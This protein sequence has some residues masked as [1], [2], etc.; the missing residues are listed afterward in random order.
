MAVAQNPYFTNMTTNTV[1]QLAPGVTFR[2][3]LCTSPLMDV[4]VLIVDMTDKNLELIPVYKLAGNVPN[5]SHERT[6]A[7][8]LR[9]DAIASVNAGYYNVTSGDPNIGMTNSYTEING[10]HIGGASGNL[11]AENN[12]SVV[13]FSGLHQ[14]IAK[15][16]KLNSSANPST[17]AQAVD[18]DKIT[19]A[20]A[21]RGHFITANGVVITQDNEGTTAGHYDSSRSRTAIGFSQNPY[22]AFLVTVDENSAQSSGVTYTQLA[23]IMADFGIENSI[24]LDGGGST[25]MYVFGRGMLTRTND[26][27][28]RSVVSAWNI[29]QANTMDNQA[30]EAVAAGTWTTDAAT[31]GAYYL[32]Q[33]VASPGA[34]GASTVTWTPT[35]GQSG[36]YKVYGWWTEDAG[37]SAAAPYEIQHRDGV[38]NVTADQRTRGRRWNLLGTYLFDAGS[39]GKV[40][41]SNAASGTVSA[42]AVR[43]VRTSD[44]PAPITPGYTVTGTV[45]QTDFE[46]DKSADFTLSHQVANGNNAADFNYNYSTFAQAG[47]G[48][49]TSIPRSPSSP[50]A[51]T[52]ALRLATNVSA[53]VINAITAT[54]TN[55]PAQ[56]N[57][58]ITFDC[59]MNYNGGI[60][61]GTGSTEFVTFGASANSS[62][63]AGAASNYL[64]TAAATNQQFNGY[65]FAA[66]GEGGSSQ[67]FRYY[68]G[69][70]SAN[71]ARGNNGSLANYL[72]N[73][74]MDHALFGR[75]FPSDQFE[76]V[77]GVG[78]AWV[79]WEIVQLNGKLRLIMTKPE[80]ASFVMCD[81]FTPN[82]GTPTS[83]VRPH[84]GVMDH[85]SSSAS[86]ASDS[87]VLVDNLKVESIAPESSVGEWSI[88]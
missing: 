5:T 79:R 84:V 82:S 33:L 41:L 6:T 18:W 31:T 58:R 11:T 65:Y 9:S 85:F 30:P 27:T 16:I 50:G 71:G 49:P 21:G 61:G 28:E 24:S 1:E 38:A 67:D 10:V 70:D 68:D 87:F 26:G 35:L 77:G 51:G 66:S 55:V 45:Y 74:A 54:L 88:Y 40:I 37:R 59:W 34:P 73:G 52:R 19:D 22:R 69:D 15:R 63:V 62:R 86:P 44:I 32:D 3:H 56:Q 83:G 23:Q 47:S 53:G 20:I 25:T 76:T 7:M 81:W 2:R 75:I 72:G 42:D 12:R 78:K 36:I 39:T 48:V 13:G 17:S 8:G 43:F 60:N 80:G 64:A 29:V 57:M 4:R 14:Q 46:T